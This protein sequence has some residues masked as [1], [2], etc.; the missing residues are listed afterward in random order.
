M[1]VILGQNLPAMRVCVHPAKRLKRVRC[2]FIIYGVPVTCL[3][4]PSPGKNTVTP[5]NVI[6]RTKC[7]KLLTQNVNKIR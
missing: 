4:S 3:R 5:Q 2:A 7:N 1:Q 6:I